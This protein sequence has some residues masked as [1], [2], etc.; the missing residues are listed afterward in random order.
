[1]LTLSKSAVTHLTFSG[2]VEQQGTHLETFQQ[3]NLLLQEENSVLKEKIFNLERYRHRRANSEYT[4][5]L[6]TEVFQHELCGFRKLGSTKV[7]NEE[8]SKSLTAKEVSLQ[9]VEK[10]LDEKTYECGVLSR[11]LQNTLDDAQR[12]VGVRSNEFYGST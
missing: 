1:M 3:K 5:K 11:Q 10:Q 6:I 8:I 12:Q 9:R 2:Q 7:Q 4:F